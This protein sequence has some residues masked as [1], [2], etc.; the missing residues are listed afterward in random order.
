MLTGFKDK[1]MQLSICVKVKVQLKVMDWQLA[2]V[3]SD[4]Q[5]REEHLTCNLFSFI[6]VAQIHLSS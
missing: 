2:L 4:D 5:S 6:Y 1:D 3:W